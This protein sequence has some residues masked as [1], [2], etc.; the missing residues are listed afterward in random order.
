MTQQ[1]MLSVT[2]GR[3]GKT[4]QIPIADGTIRATDLRQIRTDQADKGLTSYDPGL[5]NTAVTRS[6]VTSL[7]GEAGVLEYRGYPI[8]QLAA[9]ATYLEAASLLIFGKLPSAA[10]LTE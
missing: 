6:E 1:E 2:D 9:D 8:E 7:D 10:E 5:L 4:Y 3:T